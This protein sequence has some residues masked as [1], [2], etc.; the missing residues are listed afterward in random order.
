MIDAAEYL[1][2]LKALIS[3]NNQVTHI[4][5]VRE[6]AQGDS[7]LLRYRLSLQDGS[8]IEMF[9]RFHV[10][11]GDAVVTKYSYHWQDE[12]GTLLRRWD[13]APHHPEVATHPYHLHLGDKQVLSHAMLGAEDLLSTIR[14]E[15]RTRETSEE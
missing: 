4:H 12:D 11:A 1:R 10:D 7:G 8:L 6:E 2:H 5:I 14:A 3:L 13:N 15:L 9:Q